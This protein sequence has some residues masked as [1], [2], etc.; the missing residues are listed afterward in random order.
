MSRVLGR[1]RQPEFTGSNRCV[2][3]TIVNVALA[4]LLA[5]AAGIVAAPAAIPVFAAGLLAIYLRGY[6]VPKTPELTKRYA[7]EWFLA[8]FDKAERPDGGSAAV[9]EADDTADE[10]VDPEALLLS[11][12]VV[13][14]C[15]AE[16]DLCLTDSFTAAWLDDVE[17][18]RDDAEL[19][20]T[21]TGALFDHEAV[22]RDVDA[23]AIEIEVDDHGRRVASAADEQLYAWVTEGAFVADLAAAGVV[24]DRADWDEVIPEQRVAILKALR[25]FVDVC[26][27][28]DGEVAMSEDQVESCC[29]SWEVLA[30]RCRDCEEHFLEINPDTMR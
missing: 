12:G 18:L 20:R 5:G 1:Y 30:V 6:L 28:C 27:L 15:D 17:A 29:R 23:D 24:A 8:A 19:R 22:D 4:A 16:D 2:P 10:I 13:E 9:P 7:P 26:P 14:E 21:R 25:S 3:C 11:A